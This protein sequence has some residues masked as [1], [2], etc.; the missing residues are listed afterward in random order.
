MCVA[1]PD[2]PDAMLP[3]G[4][5]AEDSRT[6]LVPILPGNEPFIIYLSKYKL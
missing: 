1:A 5:K 4:Q 3:L 2:L 6:K